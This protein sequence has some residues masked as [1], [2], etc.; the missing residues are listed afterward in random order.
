MLTLYLGSLSKLKYEAAQEVLSEYNVKAK[1]IPYKVDSG[2]PL[3]PLQDE[4]YIGA[5]NRAYA[6]MGEINDENSAYVGLES[7]LV[8][9]YNTLFEETVCVILYK[10]KEYVSYSS[11]IKI[12]DHIIFAISKGRKHYEILNEIGKEK[13]VNPKDTWG[14]YT[15]FRLT[16]KIELKEAFR[17]ALINLITDNNLA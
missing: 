6:L 16:R 7:G 3:T 14:I 11:G 8:N 15:N 4:T 10:G 2:V 1:V 12:P 5:K 17:N 9:R 13:S